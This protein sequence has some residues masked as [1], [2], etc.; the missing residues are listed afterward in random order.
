MTNESPSVVA[1]ESVLK[2]QLSPS[3]TMT[4]QPCD[5]IS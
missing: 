3:K 5:D 1:L 4:F 2:E